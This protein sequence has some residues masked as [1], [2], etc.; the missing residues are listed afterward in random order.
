MVHHLSDAL[1]FSEMLRL[2]SEG[3][4]NFVVQTIYGEVSRG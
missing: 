2:V 4:G 1:H 3:F